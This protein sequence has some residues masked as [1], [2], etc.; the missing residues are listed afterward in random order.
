[1]EEEVGEGGIAYVIH[2]ALWGPLKKGIK[3]K[4]EGINSQPKLHIN[5]LIM[6]LSQ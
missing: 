1:M 4:Q 5:W 3:T 6:C 2:S